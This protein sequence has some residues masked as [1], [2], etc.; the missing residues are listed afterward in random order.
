[1]FISFVSF[2]PPSFP[3]SRAET[4]CGMIRDV[5]RNAFPQ[6]AI[7]KI[8][9]SRPVS[10][11]CCYYEWRLRTCQK[12]EV[13]LRSSIMCGSNNWTLRLLHNQKEDAAIQLS[14]RSHWARLHRH[15][16]A[17]TSCAL[18]SC[19]SSGGLLSCSQPG[20]TIWDLWLL[21]LLFGW[22]GLSALQPWRLIVLSPPNGVPSFIPRGTAYRAEWE[23]SVSEGWN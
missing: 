19:D 23:T 5:P 20:Y 16:R 22:W 15:D 18:R 9:H 4:G 17:L 13:L 11:V 1:L 8:T 10:D 6:V 3:L 7:A 14:R 2:F 12:A 21:L